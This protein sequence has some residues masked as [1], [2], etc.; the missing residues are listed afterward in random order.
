M[1]TPE[2]A[3]I[4][5]AYD[6]WLGE[7]NAVMRFSRLV[8]GNDD[9]IGIE[10]L[11]WRAIDNA[12]DD[13]VGPFTLMTTA[14]LG[15]YALARS[16]QRAELLLQVKGRQSWEDVCTLAAPLADVAFRALADGRPF[17]PDGVVPDVT[18]PL[19]TGMT[20]LLVQDRY[21]RSP[22]WLRGMVPEVRILEV[23]PLYPSEATV[24]AEIGAVET[25]RRSE[26]EGIDLNQPQRPAALLYEYPAALVPG[27]LAV[28]GTDMPN[29]GLDMDTTALLW[30]DIDTWCGHHAPR[31]ARDL[32]PGASERHI[33]RLEAFLSGLLP[34]DYRASLLTHNGDADLGPAHYLSADGVWRAASA[35]LAQE[36]AGAFAEQRI[37]RNGGGVIHDRWWHHAWVPIAREP[38][39]TLLC[40]DLDPAPAGLMGQVIRHDTITG[41]VATAHRSFEEWLRAY[42][43]DLLAGRYHVDADGYIAAP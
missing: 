40:L 3:A 43:D 5:A 12:P 22:Q 29:D 9:E 36:E 38:D 6:E 42:R 20:A 31:T 17:T 10:V 27:I 7:P 28:R 39:R 33:Q 15:A 18:F 2:L 11:F 41:P 1:A 16:Y 4:R 34:D 37:L 19:Y 25:Y 32:C 30:Q 26:Q 23:V 24:V 8:D 14:G 35:M 21:L 13:E